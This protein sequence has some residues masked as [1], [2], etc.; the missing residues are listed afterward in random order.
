MMNDGCALPGV[1]EIA[2]VPVVALDRALAGPHW[3]ALEPE[4]A[5]VEGDL[6][7]LG[8]IVGPTGICGT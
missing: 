2:Q 4:Q 3:L 6:A 7:V 5:E 1:D 8:Q